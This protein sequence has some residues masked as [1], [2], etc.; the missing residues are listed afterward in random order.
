MTAT[1]FAYSGSELDALAT[2][3]NYYRTLAA[4][5]RP[6]IGHRVLE[7]GAGVGTFA[8][9][10]LR[11]GGA[12]ELTLVEPADNNYPTLRENFAGMPGVQT[13]HG[14]LQDLLGVEQFDT[15]V[16]VNVLEHVED[17]QAFVDAAHALLKPGGT[18]LLFVPALPLIFGSL[19]HAFDHYRRYTRR[20]LGPL[21]ARAG[22][23]VV[24]LRYTNA[25]GAFAWFVSGRIL[26]RRTILPWEVRFY[27]RWMIPWITRLE[28]HFRPPFGQSLIAVAKRL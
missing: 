25:L 2:A 22:F 7:V 14:Y 27:D 6:Y 18:L 9:Y 24:D 1:Q 28:Q 12:G 15:I 5:F 16:A 19:D 21:L 8:E 13:V 10:L 17:H 20:I 23:Q 3:K 11:E 4:Q 26:R